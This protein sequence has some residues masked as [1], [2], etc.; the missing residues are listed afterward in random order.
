MQTWHHVLRKSH[1]ASMKSNTCEDEARFTVQ[2]GFERPAPADA[3][4]SPPG[5]R[6]DLAYLRVATLINI[7][8]M[9]HLPS[10]SSAT[11]ASQLG[12]AS[13]LPL[14]SR[15]LGRSISPLPLWKAIWPFVF[16]QRCAR[17]K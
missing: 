11:A 3:G 15:S 9:D 6:T 4:T 16:P 5:N 17:R 14:K 7:W 2:V 8:F 1:S 12:T 13:S 10:Q